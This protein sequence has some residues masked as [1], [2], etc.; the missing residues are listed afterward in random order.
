MT[1]PPDTRALFCF[2]LGYTARCLAARLI[3]DGWRI[4]GTTRDEDNR[5]DLE[6]LGVEVRG[7]RDGDPGA[8]LA[9]ASHILI[10]VPPDDAG[11]PIARR[12]GDEIARASGLRWLGYLSSTAVYGDRAGG[13]VDEAT[14]PAPSGE[15]G[16]RR[17][18]AEEMWRKLGVP[19]HVFRLA[20]IYGPGR[21]VLDRVRAGTARR[22]VKPGH[23]LSRIHVDDIAAVLAAS[24]ARPRPGA[25]YN[26]CDDRPASNAEVTE[27]AAELLGVAPPPEIPF[28]A[29][30]ISPEARRFFAD[31]RRVRNDLIKTELGVSLTYPDFET[32][33]RALAVGR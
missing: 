24:M 14:P 30:E 23:V 21:S 3:G 27:F 29:P 28:D 15:A 26:L 19:V 20:G 25:V 13:W 10:S 2:G 16:R 31:H 11:D 22:I 6:S 32:G 12:H 8:V 7:T 33:L 5:E 17:L 4:A 18:V 1:P 9:E